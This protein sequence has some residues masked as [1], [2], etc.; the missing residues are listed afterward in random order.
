M[1]ELSK[2]GK[3]SRLGVCLDTY[4]DLPSE[5]VF[6]FI[7]GKCFSCHTFAAGYDI[8]T[9]ET[10]EETMKQFEKIVGFHYLKAIHLN[11]SKAALVL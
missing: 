2:Y 3:T 4:V 10:Y 1:L 6:I 8:S 9:K 5:M 7:H 11:D